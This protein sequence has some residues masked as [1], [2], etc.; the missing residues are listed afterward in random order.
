[1]INDLES[2]FTDSGSPSVTVEH[3]ESNRARNEST[4]SIH[5]DPEELFPQ[6]ESIDAQNV[7]LDEL[8]ITVTPDSDYLDYEEAEIPDC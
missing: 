5:G 3:L 8:K 4:F 6:L 1:M 2:A 7:R